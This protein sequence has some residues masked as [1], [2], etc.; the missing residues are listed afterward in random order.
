MTDQSS[1][2]ASLFEP[3]MES[4]GQFVCPEWFRDAKFG[5][6]SH[7]GPQSVPMYGDWYAR[8]MYLE[9][10]PQYYYHWR[11]YGHPSKF[12]YK[13]L[14]KL[15]KAERF[16]PAGLMAL[17]VEAGARYFM[18]QAMHHDNFDNFD[19]AYNP[20]NSTKVGPMKDICALWKEQADK[21][22]LPF[23]VSEHLAASYTWLAAS[24]GADSKGPYAGVPYDGAAPENGSLYR[25][26]DSE[27][28]EA[29]E[30][31]PWYTTNPKYHVDWYNRIKDV[32]DKLQ[33]DMLYSDGGIPFGA[34]GQ[35]IVAH[36]YNS[37]AAL[38]GGVNHAVYTQKWL[39]PEGVTSIGALDI[40]RGGAD[41][42]AGRPWQCDTSIGNWF[43]DVRDVYKTAEDIIPS[44]IDVVSKNG[45]LLMN[46]TQR[47]DGTIDDEC[48]YT[49]K[50]IG[51]WFKANG[52]GIYGT[53]PY[54]HYGEGRA[55]L[56]SGSFQEGKADWKAEDYRFTRKGDAV[57][58]FRMT[59]D[60]NVRAVIKAF[61][62]LYEREI[63]RVT[64][65]GIPCAFEQKD[66]AL[67]V[68]LPANPCPGLPLCVGAETR[69]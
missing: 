62:R 16:D 33:P 27:L 31:K 63:V 11:K 65:A 25:D 52:D 40:E 17:F 56:A 42:I 44:L 59:G 20:W 6:W 66:G 49:L 58:A 19:S 30:Y 41:G 8:G 67:L 1:N 15:W 50:K 43:Y 36:L 64:A 29:P 32:I 21:F 60:G 68:D 22:G 57:Y 45:S 10:E 35:R 28:M 14:V 47:P 24:H 37:S 55:V 4:L 23:G 26:N 5:I 61:G 7:W 18:G 53:R 51:R 13:D 38:H 39:E 2:A 46:V 12:G 34:Y 69:G 3:T 9:G 54:G 48:L